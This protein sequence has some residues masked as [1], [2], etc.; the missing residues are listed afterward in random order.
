LCA[1][2]FEFPGIPGTQ[3]IP[4]SRARRG[5]FPSL[6]APGHARDGKKRPAASRSTIT[7]FPLVGDM[8]GPCSTSAISPDRTSC[9]PRTGAPT[10]LGQARQ[11]RSRPF[12][13]SRRPQRAVSAAQARCFRPESLP[14]PRNA[15]FTL[16]VFPGKPGVAEARVLK[17][18]RERPGNMLMAYGRR[19][20]CTQ[21]LATEGWGRAQKNHGL[22]ATATAGLVRGARRAGRTGRVGLSEN[23]HRIPPVLKQAATV[24]GG[25]LNYYAHISTQLGSCWPALS[26]R[27]GLTVSGTL[28]RWRIA[29][30]VVEIP[31]PGPGIS[32]KPQTIRPGH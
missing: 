11:A 22:V 30:R 25:P 9:R 17:R 31:R 14:G 24:F 4:E 15:Q 32:P 20:C 13:R 5:G 19:Y 7:I 8:W 2:A 1:T 29:E 27:K 6:V 26:R 28:G 21:A 18:D 10:C 16:P 12:S 23:G 3:V